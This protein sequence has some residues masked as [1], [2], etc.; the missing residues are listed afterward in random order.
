M[1]RFDLPKGPEGSA[2]CALGQQSDTHDRCHGA[3]RGQSV[4]TA[5]F[6]REAPWHEGAFHRSPPVALPATACHWQT[7]QVGKMALRGDF[8]VY[9][10]FP[11]AGGMRGH[12]IISKALLEPPKGRRAPHG[13]LGT[14]AVPEILV[15]LTDFGA[16]LTD[17]HRPDPLSVG[18]PYINFT[19]FDGI[20]AGG[21]RSPLSQDPYYSHR[22][23]STCGFCGPA[24]ARK[25][26]NSPKFEAKTPGHLIRTPT[27]VFMLL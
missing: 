14:P 1:V 18:F 2:R 19:D 11:R 27:A 12:Q 3:L 22:A 10:G 7:P 4:S 24:A 16:T 8:G 21:P 5:L 13:I 6:S 23:G 15:I 26:R 9:A 20:Y 17:F 25:F